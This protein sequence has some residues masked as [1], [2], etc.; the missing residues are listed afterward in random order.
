EK[1]RGGHAGLESDEREALPG[2]VG[3]TYL[4]TLADG[5]TVGDLESSLG[6]HIT[7][8]GVKRGS[9]LLTPSPGLELT[10]SDL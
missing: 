4:V 1:M 6:G 7:V 10:L 3:R 9:K 2:M 5:R 8:E